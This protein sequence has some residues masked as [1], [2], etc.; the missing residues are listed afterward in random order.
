[1]PLDSHGLDSSLEIT[2]TIQRAGS[3]SGWLWKALGWRDL[4]RAIWWLEVQGAQSKC[5]GCVATAL[6]LHRQEPHGVG[7]LKEAHGDLEGTK[8]P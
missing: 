3:L 7:R 6:R 2:G 1:M 5:Q 8:A 4:C